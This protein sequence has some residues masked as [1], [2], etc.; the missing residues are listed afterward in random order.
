MAVGSISYRT[1]T[2]RSTVSP[3]IHSACSASSACTSSSSSLP[4][5][6]PSISPIASPI[7]VS[8]RSSPTFSIHQA[9]IEVRAQEPIA[10]LEIIASVMSCWSAP[11]SRSTNGSP[12]A[13]V[14]RER[15]NGSSTWTWAG[16]TH[17][18][19]ASSMQPSSTIQA[20]LPGVFTARSKVSTSL[21]PADVD[22]IAATWNSV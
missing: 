16:S 12:A 6:V 15:S 7:I 9:L 4:V 8:M 18:P 2:S 13:F 21:N 11:N 10:M 3:E 14:L 5:M 20:G 1:G 22:W 17:R 19:Q